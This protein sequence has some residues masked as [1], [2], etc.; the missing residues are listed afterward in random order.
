MRLPEGYPAVPPI[1]TAS[2][3]R[4]VDLSQLWAAEPAAPSRHNALG[5]LATAYR[6]VRRP[7]DVMMFLIAR[8]PRRM[9]V[10]IGPWTSYERCALQAI[11]RF[12]PF[13]AAVED[14]DAH[15]W[16][17]EPDEGP[18][19]RTSTLRRVAVGTVAPRITRSPAESGVRSAQCVRGH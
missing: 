5:R 12:Q 9:R 6:E 15:C 19:R 2:L 4:D 10:G 8:T 3:P 14:I 17:L 18:L 7:Q 16:V 11:E 1:A 13:W